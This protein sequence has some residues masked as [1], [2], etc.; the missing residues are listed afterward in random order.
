MLVIVGGDVGSWVGEGAAVGV[1]VG[2]G[3]GVM[4]GVAVAVG[5]GVLVGSDVAVGVAVGNATACGIDC[6]T[7]DA[8]GVGS[9]GVGVE[10]PNGW[11]SK[12]ADLS[13]KTHAMSAIMAPAMAVSLPGRV[14]QNDSFLFPSSSASIHTFQ[15]RESLSSLRIAGLVGFCS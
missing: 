11:G 14:T 8:T 10:L 4:V 12:P 13:A 7:V 15:W 3:S 9:S 2:N 6:T 5:V 1:S